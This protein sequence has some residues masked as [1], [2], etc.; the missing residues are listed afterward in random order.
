MDPRL[1][2][3]NVHHLDDPS[4]HDRIPAPDRQAERKTLLVTTQGA[5]APAMAPA[6][7]EAGR[8]AIQGVYR[9]VVAIPEV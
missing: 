9:A 6:M 1:Q 4:L 7:A 8:E 3:A 2:F 5:M